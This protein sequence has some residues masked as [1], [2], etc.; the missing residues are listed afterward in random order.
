MTQPKDYNYEYILELKENWQNLT[1][2]FSDKELLEIF[3]EAKK[4]IPE[5]IKE[6]ECQRNQK[7]KLIISQLILI[8]NKVKDKFSRWFWREWIKN[9]EIKELLEIDSH[10]SRLRWQLS[11][12]NNKPL[13]GRITPELINQALAVPIQSLFQQPFRKSGKNFIGSCP[14]HQEKHPS[15]FIYPDTN[16]C[17]CYGCN[18]GGNIINLIRLLHGF[19]FIEAVKYLTGEN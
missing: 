19:S 3:P 2:K 10:L 5:K 17:W 9:T 8:R 15:F 14:L 6:W 11:I 16:T 18:Q 4:I 12:S 7:S 1:P 13:K